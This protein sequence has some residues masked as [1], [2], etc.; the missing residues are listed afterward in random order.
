MI[1]YAANLVC[2]AL[3]VLLFM[4]RLLVRLRALKLQQTIYNLGPK[5]HQAKQGTPNMGGILFGALTVVLAAGTGIYLALTKNTGF[6][7]KRNPLFP[8][9]AA[10]VGGMAI[11]FADDWIK[12]VK[13]R[14]EGLTPRQK[15]IGQIAVGL[16]VSAWC[17][18]TGGG[19]VRLFPFSPAALDLGVFYIPLM[20][21]AYMFITNSANL[22]DGVDGLLS[23]VTVIAM[24]A[25]GLI[26]ACGPENLSG[27]NTVCACFSFALCGACL[28]FLRFNAHPARIF[29]GD[30][31][32]MFIGGAMMGLTMVSGLELLLILL[33]FTCIVSSLSVMLQVGY[34]KITHGKRIFRM[35]PLH[36]HFELGGMS[37]NRIVLMYAAVMLL[38]CAAAVLSVVLQ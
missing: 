17:Y 34:F 12:D 25:F 31:G 36:H 9:L 4:P 19:S 26:F 7:V 22:Q 38:L 30:T 16:I 10:S 13:H 24:F 3:L 21:L 14:H 35:S 15:I 5:A 18:F 8:L 27:G 33:G 28:G 20:T 23:S 11:G 37:E 6:F 29:M 32:S 2:A 1:L